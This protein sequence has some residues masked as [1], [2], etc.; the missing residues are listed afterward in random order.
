MLTA[1]GMHTE[2]FR[3]GLVKAGQL[4]TAPM[5][6]TL[7]ISIRRILRNSFGPARVIAM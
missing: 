7:G 2:I 4:C 1:A 3:R 5:I 6:H